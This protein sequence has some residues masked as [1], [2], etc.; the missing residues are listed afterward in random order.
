M[1]LR[2]YL[3]QFTLITSVCRVTVQKIK[4]SNLLRLHGGSQLF[5]ISQL[6]TEKSR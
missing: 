4:V 3:L 2:I 6:R 5:W 1:A